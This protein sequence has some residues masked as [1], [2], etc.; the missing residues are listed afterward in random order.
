M[1]TFDFTNPT[2]A[3]VTG[4]LD[5]LLYV[6]YCTQRDTNPSVPPARWHA[7]GLGDQAME[8]RYRTEQDAGD[9][10]DETQ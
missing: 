1:K 3:K 7:L 4:L 8:E 10:R 5:E 6:S 9:N 2:A